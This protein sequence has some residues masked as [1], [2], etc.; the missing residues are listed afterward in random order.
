MIGIIPRQIAQ[1]ICRVPPR[2][3]YHRCMT[4]PR[5]SFKYI[6]GVDEVGRGPI[7]GPVTIGAVMIP[8][9]FDTNFFKG[10]RDSKKLT[11]NARERWA[12]RA[13]HARYAGL[14]SYATASTSARF[15]DEQGITRAVRRAVSRALVRFEVHPE[16]CTVLLDNLL[17]A[18]ARFVHQKAIVRGDEKEP[19][20]SLASIVAKVHR[21]RLMRRMAKAYPGYAFERHKGY[22]TREHYRRLKHH[23][24]CE[25][26]RKSFL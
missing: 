20:I 3:G 17:G 24:T 18:P 22:G 14:L 8:V 6:I 13:R 11:V 1:A 15:I 5:M 23:G 21:D 25:I 9:D 2:I 10:I 12:T 26:H 7:A 19:V 16:E 4:Q